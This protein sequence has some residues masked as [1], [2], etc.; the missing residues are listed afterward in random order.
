M[1]RASYL[2]GFAVGWLLA[3][4]LDAVDR[5]VA[6]DEA[7][8]LALRAQNEAQLAQERLAADQAPPLPEHGCCTST[9]ALRTPALNWGHQVSRAGVRIPRQRRS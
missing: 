3:P 1:S 5:M 6:K 4:V 8:I 9:E 2:V 7:L